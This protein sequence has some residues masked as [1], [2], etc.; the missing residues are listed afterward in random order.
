[1]KLVDTTDSHH[2]GDLVLSWNIEVSLGLSL[3]LES[4]SFLLGV[5]VLLDV[6]LSTFEVLGLLLLVLLKADI[7]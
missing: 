4:E 3:A 1:M 6:L 5:S 7:F 2:E